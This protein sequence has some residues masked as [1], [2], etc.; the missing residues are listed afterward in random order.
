LGHAIYLVSARDLP[1]EEVHQPQRLIAL[2]A[3]A[4]SGGQEDS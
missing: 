4:M 2:E 3:R 1:V